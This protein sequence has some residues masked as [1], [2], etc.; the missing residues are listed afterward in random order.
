MLEMSPFLKDN[1]RAE[2]K[3][4]QRLVSKVLKK[5]QRT[6]NSQYVSEISFKIYK[7]LSKRPAINEKEIDS[8]LAN[9]DNK[10]LNEVK[11]ELIFIWDKLKKSNQLYS[12]AFWQPFTDM[13][14]FPATKGPWGK[15]TAINLNNNKT[16]WQI[17]FGYEVD[18]VNGKRYKGSRNFGGASVTS[19]GVI[20]AT[21]T[22]DGYARAFNLIDGQELWADKLPFTGSSPPMTY[23]Y[24]GCQ[25]VL[26]SSTGGRYPWFGKLG[27]ATVAYR[28]KDCELSA[29][30]TN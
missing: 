6:F 21:G 28:L 25:Y 2:F 11:H 1:D 8:V 27:D 4:D 16:L 24:K 19:S 15:L 23:M 22:V 30:S 7:A 3:E 12:N 26:F 18:P 5:I 14:E 20:F 10:K 29:S 17:P 13:N 9:I